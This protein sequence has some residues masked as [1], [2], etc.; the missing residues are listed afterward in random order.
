MLIIIFYVNNF[1]GLVF[2]L[3]SGSPT[4]SISLTSK[5]SQ[6]NLVSKLRSSS[7]ATI[8]ASKNDPLFFSQIDFFSSLPLL[9][10]S[11]IEIPKI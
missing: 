6:Y 11:Y 5:I 10:N 3:I 8:I 1:H 9:K 4:S 7:Q 2:F